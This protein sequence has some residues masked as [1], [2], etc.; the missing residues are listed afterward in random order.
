MKPLLF[1]IQP[2]NPATSLRVDVRAHSCPS[3]VYAGMGGFTW[4][5]AIT[6]RPRLM[7]D[8]MSPDL[9]GKVMTGRGDFMLGLNQILNVPN[10]AALNWSGA[11][12]TIYDAT[13]L[14]YANMT[15]EFTGIVANQT[16]DIWTRQLILNLEVDKGKIDRPLLTVAFD[17]SGGIGGDANFRGTL[18]PAGYG[19]NTNC[20]PVWFDATNNVG[21][22]DGYANM[23]SVTSCF[24]GQNDLGASFGNY[25]S[26]AALVAAPITKGRWAT[27]N[28]LGLIRLGAPPAGRIACDVVFGTNRPGALIRR[29]LETNAGV[30][31][32]DVDTAAFAAVDAA[33][34][35]AVHYWTKDQRGVVDLVEKI[36]AAANASTIILL[37]GK[38][39]ITRAFGGA[40]A[41]TVNRT[42]TSTPPF[43]DWQISAQEEPV[44]RMRARTARP[45]VVFTADEIFY[46]DNLKDMG[47]WNVLTTYRIGMLA[48]LANGS[49][50]L[51]VNAVP[52]AG[53]AP[54]APPATS[55]TW[56]QQT[57]PPSTAAD[58]LYA[59]GTPVENLKPTEIGATQN[60]VIYSA[61]DPAPKPNG[62]VW[63]DTSATVEVTK[64]RVG[65]VWVIAA[66]YVQSLVELDP[67]AAAQLATALAS[68][69]AASDDNV[70][71]IEEKIAD[72]LPVVD[73]LG[74]RYTLL[75]SAAGGLSISA[76]AAT[77]SR[78]AFLAYLA[79]LSP[80]YD[81]VNVATT[82][83]ATLAVD[84]FVTGWT[85]NVGATSAANGNYRTL[86]DPNAGGI[87]YWSSVFT[88]TVSQ[89]YTVAMVVKRDAVPGATRN[90]TLRIATN[91][92]TAKNADV[93]I[94]T[95]TGALA[96]AGT[97]SDFG[98]VTLNDTEW[99]VWVSM[100]LNAN[101]T[102][103]LMIVL[104][105]SN[106]AA[107]TGSVDV[108]GAVAVLGGVDKIG[109]DRW[110]YLLKDYAFQLDQLA[111]SILIEQ[112]KRSATFTPV[113][114]G[115][116]VP[117]IAGQSFT[118][119]GANGW[120]CG[121]RAD[122]IVNAGF[123]EMNIHT[124]TYSMV[125]FDASATDYLN[126]N[127]DIL[128]YYDYV[129]GTLTV[130]MAGV[131]V[132]NGTNIG[133][134]KTGKIR[135]T[136]DG[137][138]F[139]VFVGI[140]Q[141]GGDFAASPNLSLYPKWLA[142]TAGLYTGLSAAQIGS[143]NNFPDM[144]GVGVPSPNA[145]TTVNLTAIGTAG[146][147]I[148]GNSFLKTSGG[149]G[150]SGG[151]VCDPVVGPQYI[152]C[153]IRAGSNYTVI[154]LD[155]NATDY[156]L[157]TNILF[158]IYYNSG[159]GDWYVGTNAANILNG[160]TSTGLTGKLRIDYDGLYYR[161]YIGGTQMAPPYAATA[162]N[163][164]LWPKWWAHSQSIQYSGAFNGTLALNQTQLILT[165][166][167]T[168]PATFREDTCT[169]VSASAWDSGVRGPALTHAMFVRANIDPT[170]YT[171]VALDTSATDYGYDNQTVCALYNSTSGQVGIYLNSSGPTYGTTIATG[172]TGQIVLV[173][174]GNRY[175]LFLG[176]VQYGGD[177]IFATPNQTLYPKWLFYNAAT[178]TGL[179][180]GPF[181]DNLW[182]N[183]G[184]L[185]RPADNASSG[186][187]KVVNGNAESGTT[188]AWYR[189]SSYSPQ[190]Y[191]GGNDFT[192]STSN[193]HSG[194]KA[195]LISKSSVANAMMQPGR[196]IAVQPGK[197]YTFRVWL[198]GWASSASGLY[199]GLNKSATL[200]A[201][202][203]I[204]SAAASGRDD[205]VSNAPCPT[206][207]TLYEMIW[208]CPAGTYFVS[209]NIV[210]FTNCPSV[211]FDDVEFYEELDVPNLNVPP[212]Q[213]VY[214]N[215]L[216]A[217]LTG[218]L[219][220]D[221][222][223]NLLRGSA[224]VSALAAW[225]YTP[226]NCTIT[227]GANGLFTLNTVT[228][229]DAQVL[230]SATYNGP[231]VVDIIKIN[232]LDDA[233]PSA[234]GAGATS[235]DVTG[236]AD[237]T[238]TGYG[239]VQVIATGTM[240]TNGA[241]Q[242][243]LV[244]SL[245]YP[246]PGGTIGKSCYL[247]AKWQRSAV[248]AGV[249]SDA[250]VAAVGSTAQGGPT[251]ADWLAG[252]FST[253]ALCTAATA[254]TDY[255][256]RLIG[257]GTFTGSVTHVYP[258][259]PCQGFQS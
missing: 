23:T 209:P 238:A 130:V 115:T 117:T 107:T 22:L 222:Q 125:A 32:G 149:A 73:S 206:V 172:I 44:W 84:D 126:T 24:E 163:L 41:G 92:G 212:T 40:S 116:N 256:W 207:Y 127:Q 199:I 219:T 155:D 94:D 33:V 103:C 232:R 59:D 188:E 186:A 123:V 190:A 223:S 240:R 227:A 247:T 58:M 80:A 162:P 16:L 99:L 74:A 63:V 134:G 192:V 4:E 242:V 147:T 46:E 146:M 108:R 236:S 183:M 15:V 17:G 43:T 11:P 81:N 176:G 173:C 110:K 79:A 87:S 111:N 29:I 216:G 215:Y 249:W 184:G 71:S 258:G 138:R 56:W 76:A 70:F 157:G 35:R 69:V 51:F 72:V 105:A 3:P 54:P 27:C 185:R 193:N 156:G 231:A 77:A 14:D 9:D 154:G 230:V 20:E 214:A 25:A 229:R 85:A 202:G 168:S 144:G 194:A 131:T 137:V 210:P 161:A 164:K 88:T 78:A 37:N 101:N 211:S 220:R 196:A 66:N 208:T 237:I 113:A 53:N 171:V 96:S 197:K 141:F 259:G 234:G 174:D 100:V 5:G 95:S 143:T 151:A 120:D 30:S 122:P 31:V 64:L 104:P 83:S 158:F 203:Y 217:P 221:L 235:F 142:F 213:Y 129:G 191:G 133:A 8:L 167:G 253:N 251:P 86:T 243:R 13:S 1:L 224:D 152:E 102:Q 246:S 50:W 49:Q 205:I 82:L 47:L 45:G 257:F 118:K 114:I 112:A 89:T 239:T 228:G 109:R 195:F 68:A 12:V 241:G 57:K 165:S 189:D 136:Y 254:S 60:Q 169:K 52:S 93:I 90:I 128:A 67:T 225:V 181:T 166:I 201:V 28:A 124:T 255:D 18:A 140:A 187:N 204:D 182:D 177:L 135:I 160:T 244:A 180:A 179:S 248:G 218:Q 153:D 6:R 48:W 252:T 170:G 198:I 34:N 145:G 106:A 75:N 98:S 121:V 7:Q 61:A 65:G 178:F 42:G 159:T 97:P 148:T 2:L 226:S 36:S 55:N 10:P 200:P 245:D 150:F 39:S 21:M 250:G 38:I 119:T 139:R 62:T 91:T 132:V 175:R 26:Y 233:P 19:A